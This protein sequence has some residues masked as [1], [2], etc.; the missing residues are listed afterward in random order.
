MQSSY[1]LV[2]VEKKIFYEYRKHV[3]GKP[4]ILFCIIYNVNKPQTAATLRRLHKAKWFHWVGSSCRAGTQLHHS[5]QVGKFIIGFIILFNN[6]Q[7][8]PEANC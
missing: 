3:P 2:H 5:T 8:S 4:L 7:G 6:Q 1:K